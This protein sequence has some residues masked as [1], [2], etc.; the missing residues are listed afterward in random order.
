MLVPVV[1]SDSR[2]YGGENK[3]CLSIV[4]GIAVVILVVVLVVGVSSKSS[5]SKTNEWYGV[6][7]NSVVCRL[8]DG[9][10]MIR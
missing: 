10:A 3:I 1:T 2:I 4:F 6:V 5:P 7:C 9:D 8:L